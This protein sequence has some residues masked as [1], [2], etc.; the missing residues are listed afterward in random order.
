MAIPSSAL[1]PGAEP[2]H[3]PIGNAEADAALK[4]YQ[5]QRWRGLDHWPKAGESWRVV[6][7]QVVS[8]GVENEGART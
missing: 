5:E 8:L 3:D 1:E 7:G 6:D 4:Q 2:A